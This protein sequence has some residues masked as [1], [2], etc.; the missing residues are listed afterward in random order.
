VHQL[1]AGVLRTRPMDRPVYDP[2]KP[3]GGHG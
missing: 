3:K 2:T 1:R